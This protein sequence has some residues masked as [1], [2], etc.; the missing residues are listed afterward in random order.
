MWFSISKWRWVIYAVMHNVMIK[1]RGREGVEEKLFCGILLW[2]HRWTDAGAVNTHCFYTSITL[3][4][5]N[6][7]Q[8]CFQA[9]LAFSSIRTS[10]SVGNE[11]LRMS[12]DLIFIPALLVLPSTFNSINFQL[13]IFF[14]SSFK[15]NSFIDI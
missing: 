14:P 4:V 9:S 3:S 12:N 15:N 8:S 5:L 10:L 11:L 1:G 6:S 13:V 2:Q 7:G